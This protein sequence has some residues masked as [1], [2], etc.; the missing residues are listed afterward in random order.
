MKIPR[1]QKE[2]LQTALHY[3]STPFL[4]VLDILLLHGLELPNV[5]WAYRTTKRI[6]TGETPYSLAFGKEVVLPI[7]QRQTT[8]RVHHYEQEDNEAKLK[9]NWTF[10][11]RST[12]RT[13]HHNW[14]ALRP[15]EL[16]STPDALDRVNPSRRIAITGSP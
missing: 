12:I 2:I 4:R 3:P 13:F 16:Y 7:K 8:F 14:I 9:A 5:L 10:S 11:R 1:Q 6:A 15:G